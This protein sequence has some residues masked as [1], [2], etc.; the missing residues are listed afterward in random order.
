[1]KIEIT[2]KIL[3]RAERSYHLIVTLD[4]KKIVYY[5]TTHIHNGVET[6][7]SLKK[8]DYTKVTTSEKKLI[9]MTIERMF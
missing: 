4:D 6:L 8:S 3:L 5:V 1:M 9:K 2:E 7:F